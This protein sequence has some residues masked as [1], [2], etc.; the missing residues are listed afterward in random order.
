M[1]CRY[2]EPSDIPRL[3]EAYAR[4]RGQEIDAKSL[5][6]RLGGRDRVVIVEDEAGYEIGVAVYRTDGKAIELVDL[7]LDKG[8]IG[9]AL[10]ALRAEMWPESARVRVELPADDAEALC[11]WRKLGF[12]DSKITLEAA[13][14]DA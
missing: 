7:S 6:N 10:G 9:E 11:A 4:R 1:H 8:E 5:D 14:G 12:R 13:F 3:A 2:A